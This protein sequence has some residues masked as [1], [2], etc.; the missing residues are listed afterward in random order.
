MNILLLPFRAL[1]FFKHRIKNLCA[2]A[3]RNLAPPEMLYF[4]T[5]NYKHFKEHI[6]MPFTLAVYRSVSAP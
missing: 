6:P 1:E 3:T 4:H 5:H 2:S